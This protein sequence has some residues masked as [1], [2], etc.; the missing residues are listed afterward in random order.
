MSIAMKTNKYIFRPPRRGIGIMILMILGC[1]SLFAQQLQFTKPFDFTI[2]QNFF[3]EEKTDEN[4]TFVH[5]KHNDMDKTGVVGAPELPVEYV[6]ISVPYNA[7]NIQITATRTVSRTLSLG[8]YVYPVQESVPIGQEI[9]FTQPDPSIYSQSTLYPNK[10]AEIVGVGFFDG[11][12]QVVT[13][14]LY[15]TEFS[16]TNRSL[17]LSSK[18]TFQLRF[19][20]TSPS[21]MP[22]P[23]VI[24]RWRN[25]EKIDILKSMVINP[26]SVLS[27]A[28]TTPQN[29][30]PQSTAA[31]PIY[32]YVIVTADSLRPAFDRFVAWKRQKGY[33]VKVEAIE[34]IL[35]ST[36]YANGDEVSGI[37]DDAGKLRA[38]LRQCYINN[39]T[40]FVLLAGDY[41]IMPIRY[42]TGNSYLGTNQVPTDLYFS[43]FGSNWN[44]NNNNLYGEYIDNISFEP[45]V[46][47]GRLLCKNSIHILNY[48]EKLIRYE[49]NPGSG[50][51]NY[52]KNAVY[53]KG[54]EF[55]PSM[56]IQAFSP[57]FEQ[58]DTIIRE[59]KKI[60]GDTISPFPYG[61]D[62][63]NEL[64]KGYGYC[65]IYNHGNPGGITTARIW[66]YV[67]KNG[68]YR[69]TDIVSYG[70]NAIE[71]VSCFYSDVKEFSDNANNS[72]SNLENA[73]KPY[74]FYSISC[75]TTPFDIFTQIQD[76][77]SY[78]Y[79]IEYNMGSAFTVAGKYGGP[80]FLGNTRHGYVT[81]S[82][83]LEKHFADAVVTGNNKIGIA[84]AIS[85]SALSDNH[86]IKLAHNLIGEPEFE[87]WTDIPTDFTNISV[88]RTDNNIV[89]SGSELTNCYV[90]VSSDNGSYVQN[91]GTS[92]A[93]TF[94][95]VDPNSIVT[96][97]KHNYI[98]YIPVVLQNATLACDKYIVATTAQ[99][100]SA[101]DP[102]RTV[103]DFI[104][105][106]DVTLNIQASQNVELH[107]GF[108]VQP[109]GNANIRTDAT[110]Y[111]NGM[112]GDV[113]ISE[114]DEV[115]ITSEFVAYASD[116]I[117]IRSN[118]KVKILGGK[119]K[120]GSQLRICAPSVE[121]IQ[122]F[123][124]E[125]GA[126]IEI[127]N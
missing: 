65:S 58:T 21:N 96:V 12:N 118:Q 50:D 2:G 18:I 67:E 115:C 31:N 123:E 113:F 16:P 68:G 126:T 91:L 37:N 47:V 125:K 109:G 27:F 111:I 35:S 45:S 86:H 120:A 114:A 9:T 41:T 62:V 107:N 17:R 103:G 28:P 33:N 69:L 124:T 102:N 89:V 71:G 121:I 36:T 43:E 57:I 110:V 85:K 26:E 76:T 7:V 108:V 22:T 99:L 38:Y 101:I 6:R 75:H 29:K 92:A 60:V 8:R 4:G 40:E 78:T 54:D 90:G 87:M 64:K 25:P 53:V 84:E 83:K 14:A 42:G 100:G 72:F 56:T 88:Q 93:A 30:P 73:T 106:T 104:V 20:I 55:D 105:P 51:R 79:E 80:A 122:N 10:V 46:F 112:N 77:T 119:L 81:N 19:N 3:I 97:Y 82:I 5:L 52:L 13:V 39:G 48:T 1:M 11:C 127:A 74:I 32:D 61:K 24:P 117:T 15:P 95:N 63:I 44:K 66:D 49:L 116:N 98:P 34:N 70:I 23:P 59:N 94:S